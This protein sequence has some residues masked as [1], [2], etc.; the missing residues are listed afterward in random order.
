MQSPYRHLVSFP[1]V[2]LKPDSPEPGVA[3]NN[4]VLVWS[5][6][7]GYQ[8]RHSHH[9]LTKLA[10]LLASP[11]R[12]LSCLAVVRPRTLQCVRCASRQPAYV[13]QSISLPRHMGRRESCPFHLLLHKAQSTRC[14]AKGKAAPPSCHDRRSGLYSINLRLSRLMKK[15]IE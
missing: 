9:I 1:L 8:D 13:G 2:V 11:V 3:K 4:E 6:A 14:R 7:T 10:P 15:L 12:L 5:G